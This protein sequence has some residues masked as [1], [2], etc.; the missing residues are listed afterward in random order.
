MNCF[1]CGGL[2]KHIGQHTLGQL[3]DVGADVEMCVLGCVGMGVVL[4]AHPHMH[5]APSVFTHQHQ[6]TPMHT[7][8]PLSPKSNDGNPIIPNPCVDKVHIYTRY[9]HLQGTYMRIQD[10]YLHLQGTHLYKVVVRVGCP[11]WIC[12]A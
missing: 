8:N 1:H 5:D 3:G 12:L 6:H 10:T 4:S 11:P 2:A 9:I 7:P